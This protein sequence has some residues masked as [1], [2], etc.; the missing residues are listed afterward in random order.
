VPADRFARAAR[1]V[2]WCAGPLLGA[3]TLAVAL[4]APSY[5][6][7]ADPMPDA[8][9]LPGTGA[10]LMACSLVYW[11]Q[12]P[13]LIGGPL[14]AATGVAWFASGWDSPGTDPSD[15]GGIAF[16]LGLALGAVVPAL[17]AHLA[18]VHPG[19]G[20]TSWVRR[21]VTVA[22]YACTAGLLGVGGAA[23]FDPAAGGCR[24]PTNWLLIH[25]R[26]GL[27]KDVNQI[28]LALSTAWA[29]VTIALIGV[30]IAHATPAARRLTSPVR[31]A[32]AACLAV[33][34]LWYWGSVRRG[35]VG[36]TAT[37]QTFWR[38]QAVTLLALT[39]TVSW[40]LLRSRR[41]RSRLAAIIT[42]AS[43][44]SLRDELAS[45]LDDPALVIAHRLDDGRLVDT[46]ATAVPLPPSDG[47]IATALPTTGPAPVLIH[48]DGALDSPTLIEELAFAA[49]LALR[50]DRL[51][52]QTLVQL[53]DLHASQARIVE[54]G[55]DERRRLERDLHDGAQQR[56][57]GLLLALRL[58]GARMDGHVN[59]VTAA[60]SE[61][62]LAVDDLRDLAH[63]LFPSVLRDEGLAAALDA[64]SETHPLRVAAAPTLRLPAVLET[65]AYL[66]VARAA[67]AGPTSVGAIAAAEGLR[68]TV[69]VRGQVSDLSDLAD[70]AAALGGVLT[71]SDCADGSTT[72][73]L[74]L[75]AAHSRAREVGGGVTPSPGPSDSAKDRHDDP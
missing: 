26:P 48:R 43:G 28:G 74:T 55:D 38:A 53:A 70:R 4:A 24:C 54:A 60:E 40:Q 27:L 3:Y 41:V 42:T 6:F 21:R 59:Q 7:L 22:G 14:L 56:L 69:H 67:D 18:L 68:L 25:D 29:I 49:A 66:L 10:A 63:G 20:S 64:L 44:H 62:S 52:A 13:D 73:S 8:A 47:R 65:T 72:L 50:N 11:S 37:D 12:R 31:A 75:P 46:E 16:S 57:V 9:L 5:A 19:G 17:V 1:I 39:A 32:A 51:R 58:L 30:Q 33:T 23:F 2:L 35:F 15:A 36:T 71:S 45:L 61:V 34:A